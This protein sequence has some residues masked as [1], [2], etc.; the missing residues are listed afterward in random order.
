MKAFP[1][2]GFFG[3]AFQLPGRFTHQTPQ[4]REAQL[5]PSPTI[6]AGVPAWGALTGLQHVGRDVRDRRCARGA[7][8]IAQRLGQKGPEHNLCGEDVV[9][10]KQRLLFAEDTLDPFRVQHM[11]E[12]QSFALEKRV[13]DRIKSALVACSVIGYRAHDKALPGFVGHQAKE[14][15]KNIGQRGPQTS[16]YSGCAGA[17]RQR[18]TEIAT[19]PVV[20]RW[21]VCAESAQKHTAVPFVTVPGLPIG[22]V[23]SLLLGFA[24][25]A[26][27][28][29]LRR[30][31]CDLS[32]GRDVGGARHRLYWRAGLP[33]KEKA[34][35]ETAQC[36]TR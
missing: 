33:V 34:D 9:L 16:H 5:G 11:R 31:G 10:A 3:V 8:A 6:V 32:S 15:I 13:A 2:P 28:T 36:R 25:S 21:K 18:G 20:R 17:I 24:D 19:D 29:L 12:G 7:L 35:P 1:Q 27:P 26:Q 14:G 30:R 23:P 22:A 4:G